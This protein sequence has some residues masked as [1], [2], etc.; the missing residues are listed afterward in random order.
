MPLDGGFHAAPG[1][2]GG[3][4]F[5]S[6]GILYKLKPIVYTSHLV[7]S[8]TT[9]PGDSAVLSRGDVGAR[10]TYSPDSRRPSHTDTPRDQ[11]IPLLTLPLSLIHI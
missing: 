4:Y 1:L 6:G 7:F 8:L 2:R 3:R 5:A 10:V 9:F 11:A